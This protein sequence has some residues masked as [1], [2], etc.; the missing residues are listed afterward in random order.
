MKV[1]TMRNIYLLSACSVLALSAR[2]NYPSNV[3][4]NFGAAV[5]QNIQMQTVNPDAALESQQAAK[6]DGQSAKASID[7]YQRSFEV[8]PLPTNVFNIGVGSG[9]AAGVAR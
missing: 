7:R 6:S 5:R 2:S 3:D 9:A 1:K 8:L 4:D